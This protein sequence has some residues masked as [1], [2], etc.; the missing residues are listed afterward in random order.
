[1]ASF[2]KVPKTEHPKALKIHVFDC[3]WM[4]LLQE[5][6]AN[7]R[8]NRILPE[9]RVTGLHLRHFVAES[10]GPSSFKYSWWSQK[11]HVF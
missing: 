5:T 2:P 7:I 3:H 9:T 1:M 10:L 11:M 4:S 8:K 6:A